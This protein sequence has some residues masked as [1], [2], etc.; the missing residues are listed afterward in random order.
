MAVFGQ[1]GYGIGGL[2]FGRGS[3]SSSSRSF[4]PRGVA[5]RPIAGLAREYNRA[6]GQAK[7]ANEQRYRQLLAAAGQTTG[8]RA[9]DIKTAYGRRQSDLM[10]QLA[11][12]GLAGSTAGIGSTLTSGLERDRQAALNNLAD[13][14]QQTRLGIIER[15]QD[16]YPDANLLLGIAGL[17]GP[18]ATA[19]GALASAL[20]FGGPT[21]RR[22]GALTRDRLTVAPETASRSTSAAQTSVPRGGGGGGSGR[23]NP[24]ITPTEPPYFGPGGGGFQGGGGGFGGGGA[25]GGGAGGSGAGG[26]GGLAGIGGWPTRPNPTGL[27]GGQYPLREGPSGSGV[28][29]P[30]S[31][32]QP[33]TPDGDPIGAD[34]RIYGLWTPE[35]WAVLPQVVK[36]QAR[37]K[38]AGGGGVTAGG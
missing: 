25:G 22:G 18:A 21:P 10:Q 36:D 29:V 20:G 33:T 32:A 16:K 6:F 27:P 34:G 4:T 38:A 3:S 35:N 14:L 30:I 26:S 11:R 13:Q 7:A 8:Q 28:R 15:K 12:S 9:A 31:S 23:A 1:L 37:A 24:G 2:G 19:G 5:P 17:T